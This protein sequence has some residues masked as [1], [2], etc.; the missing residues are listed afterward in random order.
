MQNTT[1]IL[2]PAAGSAQGNRVEALLREHLP[3]ARILIAN[4]GN[5]LS[6]LARQAVAEGSSML[7]AGGGDGTI[8]TVAQELVG[9]PATLGLL[10]LGTRNH[11]VQDVGVPLDLEQAVRTLVKGEIQMIDVGEVNGRTFLL[12]AAVGLYPLFVRER[13]CH[14][15]I[16]RRHAPL[17]F[18]RAFWVAL[19]RYPYLNVQLAADRDD[20]AIRTPFVF[21]A[22]NIATVEH[23][24]FGVV[25]CPEVGQLG[26]YTAH[27]VTRLGLLRLAVHFLADNLAEAPDL[28]AL[29]T[30]HVTLKTHGSSV[31][32]ATDGEVVRMKAP[33]QACVR[34][35]A[36]RVRVPRVE[37]Q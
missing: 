2:N 34:L 12:Y 25:T 6:A 20:L 19:R 27:G 4:A 9:K 7:V 21:I 15:R 26:V 35:G 32:V 23:L 36:L 24:P 16:G 11:F 3:E 28:Q 8:R 30:R 18:A 33:L 17:A 1:V 5:E 37:Q 13:E 31:W 29:S 14:E 10:P 22:N